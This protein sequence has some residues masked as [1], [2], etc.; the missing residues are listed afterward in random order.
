MHLVPGNTFVFLQVVPGTKCCQS[1]LFRSKNNVFG[2]G[3]K[4]Q[5]KAFFKEKIIKLPSKK[6]FFLGGGGL[7]NSK[8]LIFKP[9]KI[10]RSIWY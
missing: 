3:Q 9:K 2:P 10:A 8:D 6:A 5:K 7:N 1:K 4:P